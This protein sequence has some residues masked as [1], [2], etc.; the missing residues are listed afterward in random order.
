MTKGASV[1]GKVVP[2]PNGDWSESK[3]YSKLD[4]VYYDK[5]S[6]IAKKEVPAAIPLP[7]NSNS[8]EYWQLLAEGTPGGPGEQGIQG[9]KGEKGDFYYPIFDVDFTTG[10][11]FL[12][13]YDNIES[14]NHPTLS[15]DDNGNLNVEWG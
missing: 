13:Y 15:V 6:Y 5:K 3:R 9:E 1:I 11:L 2:I 10:E 8:N 14:K 7:E 12:I 4:I